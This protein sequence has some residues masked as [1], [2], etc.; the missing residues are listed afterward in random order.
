MWA[1]NICVKLR[2][3]SPCGLK[4]L[5]VNFHWKFYTLGNFDK[6]IVEVVEAKFCFSIYII[7]VAKKISQLTIV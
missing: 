2:E 6:Q 7:H 3:A 1:I 5:G 4:N